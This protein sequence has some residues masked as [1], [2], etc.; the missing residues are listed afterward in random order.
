MYVCVMCIQ[1]ASVNNC[2]RVIK[3]FVILS[4]YFQTICKV[5]LESITI[6]MGTYKISILLIKVKRDF[7]NMNFTFV[8]IK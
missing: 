1:T 8:V 4:V 7:Q 6:K 3:H 2:Q 5:A